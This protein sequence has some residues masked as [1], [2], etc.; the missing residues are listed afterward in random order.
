MF[1]PSRFTA[2]VPKLRIDLIDEEDAEID[3]TAARTSE[4][5]C[6]VHAE[7]S[8]LPTDGSMDLRPRLI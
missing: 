8:I 2:S 7:E 6:A 3:G 1:A 5:P 4:R